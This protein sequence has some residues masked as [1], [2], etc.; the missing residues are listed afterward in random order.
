MKTRKIRLLSALLALAMLLALLPTAAFAETSNDYNYSIDSNGNV[1][2]TKYIGSGGDV[3]IPEELD[4]HPVTI[5]GEQ[6]FLECTGLTS[7]VIPS[8][9]MKVKANAFTW[10]ENLTS[11]TFGVG[12]ECNRLESNVFM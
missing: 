4:G 9:V 12:F 11:V 3:V 1:T 2:I 8:N 7:V 6:A 10:C 5:I